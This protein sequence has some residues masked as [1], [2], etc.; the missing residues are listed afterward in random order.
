MAQL[1]ADIRG[2]LIPVTEA[3]V[4]LPNASVSEVITYGTPQAIDGM[5][6]WV[7]G[8]ITWRGWRIPLFSFSLL[9]GEA[10]EENFSGA[11]VA[12]IKALTG[13]GDMPFMALLAQGFPRLT[14]VTQENLLMEGEQDALPPGV[15]HGVNINDEPAFVPDL[16]AIERRLLEIVGMRESGPDSLRSASE[17][18]LASDPSSA[19][20]AESAAPEDPVTDDRGPQDEVH[21]E[22]P[23][24][25]SKAEETEYIDPDQAALQDIIDEMEGGGGN[26]DDDPLASFELGDDDDDEPSFELADDD[27]PSM[28]IDLDED[29]DESDDSSD[30]DFDLDFDFGFDDEDDDKS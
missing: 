25:A 19:P 21:D 22:A 27:E 3:R 4:L 24:A 11:K 9:S 5:P 1:A 17:L 23:A 6:D 28:S 10:R 2:V 26:E 18:A 14:A 16:D 7:F 29:Q 30:D 15:I 8:A 13:E 12:I 20:D